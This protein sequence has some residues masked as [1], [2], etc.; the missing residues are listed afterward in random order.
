MKQQFFRK[1][2]LSYY[3]VG[4]IFL[5]L[6][7]ALVGLIGISY[8]ATERTLQENA[9][10]GELQ[11]E[12]NLV[13]V[14]RSKEEG[15]RIYEESLNQRM[16]EAFHPFL[17]EYQRAGGDPSRMDLGAVKAALGGEMELYVIDE[18]ATI[19]ATT[20]PAE[21][22]LR[23][24]DYA[25]Y[26]VDYLNNIRQ[27]GEFHPDRI[28]SEKS[29]GAMKKFAYLPT[30]DHRYILELGLPVQI[31]DIASFRFLDKE[32]IMQV[33]RDNPY[34]QGVRVF[35][36]TLRLRENDT[37]V[38]ID[39]PALRQILSGVLANRTTIEFADPQSGTIT[40]YLFVELGNDAF[41]SD[42]S[43]IIELV[44]TD[45]PVRDALHSSI[46]SYLT[47]GLIALFTCAVLAVI[48]IRRIT[49]P[50]GK[51]V[52][53]VD[54][55]AGGDLD[56]SLSPP[57]GAELIQLE[58]SITTMVTRLK[59]S[60]RQH[61][62]SEKRFTDIVQLL[63]QGVFETDL[64]GNVTFANP[65]AL[66]VFQLTFDDI[67]KGVNVF[68]L[69]IPQDR[70]PARERFQNILLG[71]KSKGIEVTAIRKDGS[72]FPLIVYNTAIMEGETPIGS[73]GGFVDIT[74]LKNIE[75]E[76]RNLNRE[77]EQRVAD[78]TRQLVE[79][80]RNLESFTY[81]VS[82]DLRAPLRAISGF[83]SILLHD[84]PD[85][86]EADRKYLNLIQQNAN[87]MGQLIDDL[88]GFSRLGQ[89]SL[90][91]K[92]V[93][94]ATLVREVIQDM[95]TETN[96]AK[97]E[98]R[99]GDLPLCKADPVLM[100]QLVANLLSNAIKFSRV[101]DH[102][103]VEIGSLI[104]DGKQVYFV[105]DNGIGF[106]MRYATKIFGVFERLD[107]TDEYEGTGVG[108]AIVLRIIELHGG[109]IW[110][111]S[112]VDKGTTFYFTCD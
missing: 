27:T 23:F 65:K 83:S 29:T 10:S 68:D 16:E 61:Q 9:R 41:G 79:V 45:Q 69:L 17:A 110:V 104:K 50:I 32:L 43:R 22:G 106:D 42:V 80:N 74:N 88:L 71:G 2:P 89:Y 21:L 85:I 14:F 31:P 77:L 52:D 15:I 76:I 53:D 54:I 47:L 99:I 72:T 34:L 62:M 84:L 11:A 36:S 91:K 55:I 86:P 92:P 58:Q 102:P 96:L 75:A 37:S 87:E 25:P 1:Y 8:L 6:M 98:F 81:S 60:I 107:T 56:H 59:E 7:G 12:N 13:A 70:V 63:P 18:N 97:V 57:F 38:E 33:E 24:G 73:R 109:K 100:R 66:E 67:R 46:I 64:D 94:L 5:I 49:Q 112:E 78:R 103:L 111:E 82:H 93:L 20:Y 30:P 90:Q 108:L 95:Q 28:V 48:A 44:Y 19:I 40:R 101:R 51:M 35:D 105:R 3:L 4:V 26:F 39:D